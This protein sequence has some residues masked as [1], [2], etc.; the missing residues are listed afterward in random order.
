[1][2]L[3][4]DKNSK[5]GSMNGVW[6]YPTSQHPAIRIS[7]YENCW[8]ISYGAYGTYRAYGAHGTFGTN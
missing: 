7:K 8:S 5:C 3:L 4:I 1:V 6:V 2:C